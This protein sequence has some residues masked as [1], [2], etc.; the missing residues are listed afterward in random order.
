MDGWLH[1]VALLRRQLTIHSLFLYTFH[2]APPPDNLTV[3]S[4]EATS[5]V[6]SWTL[7]P[8]TSYYLV[9]RF[10]GPCMDVVVPTHTILVE[11]GASNVTDLE[12]SSTYVV[13]VTPQGGRSPAN[14]TF[15]TLSAGGWVGEWVI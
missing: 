15:T 2:S 14:T 7:T 9:V 8:N 6:F 1:A 10:T 4:I 11:G 3:D 5:A 12:E 13:M